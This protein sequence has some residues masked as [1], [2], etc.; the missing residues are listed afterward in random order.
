[1]REEI[2]QGRWPVPLDFALSGIF[3]E[4]W[5]HLI[6]NL[7]A[8]VANRFR[9]AEDHLVACRDCLWE[10]RK[11]MMRPLIS[12]P[13]HDKEAVLP[14]PD[15]H[16]WQFIGTPSLWE[17]EQPYT[18]KKDRRVLRGRNRVHYESSERASRL[19][20]RPNVPIGSKQLGLVWSRFARAR[21][22]D[23]FR[24][25]DISKSHDAAI[26]PTRAAVCWPSSLGI[27]HRPQK[28]HTHTRTFEADTSHSTITTN[29]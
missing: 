21:V 27:C 14:I 15:S 29:E 16:E 5:L 17:S 20:Y 2:F 6:T 25:S 8:L 9:M 1:M 13:L 24:L 3:G 19:S 26:E 22:L 18:R 23:T 11:E 4:A 12:E 7:T 28:F 10:G